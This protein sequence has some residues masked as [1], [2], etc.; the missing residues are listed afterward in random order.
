MTIRDDYRSQD[1]ISYEEAA[2]LSGLSRSR[3]KS[4]AATVKDGRR[5]FAKAHAVGPY[6]VDRSTFVEYLRTGRPCGPRDE[7][8]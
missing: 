3:V 7:E 4:L 8:A 6:R 2:D 1:A 5:L